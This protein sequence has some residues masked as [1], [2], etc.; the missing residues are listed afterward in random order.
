M[1]TKH[2]TRLAAT[3]LVDYRPPAYRV[4][5]TEL[6]LDLDAAETK[7]YARHQV[8]KNAAGPNSPHL[9]LDAE[10]LQ[11]GEIH[12][13]GKILTA[14]QYAYAHNKLTI[15][16]SP[17][18]FELEINNTIAPNKNTALSGLYASG[19]MLC[20]QCEA[21]GFRRITAGVD[22]PD[23]LSVYRV[24]LRADKTTMPLLL[25][26]GNLVERGELPAGKHFTTWHDPFPKPTYLF[27]AVAG[28]LACR[29][30]RFV[31]QSG[32]EV[33]LRLF[34]APRDIDKCAHALSALKRAMDWD[35]KN[36]GREYDLDA[37]HIVAVEN[38]NMGAMENKSLNIF[39]TKYILADPRVATDA[40]FENVEAVVAHEYFHNWSGNR[41]TCRDWFQLSL[42]EGFTVFREQQFCADRGLVTCDRIADAAFIRDA[43]FSE[44]SGPMAHAVR[45]DSY[46][47]INNFYTATVYNKGAEVIRMLHTILGADNFRRG[48][49]L[50]FSRHDGRAATTDDFV[51]AMAD[52]GAADLTAFQRW[53]SQAGTPVVDAHTEYNAA[54]KTFRVTLT[55]HCPPTPGQPTKLP[56]VIPVRAALFDHNGRRLPAALHPDTAAACKMDYETN[57]PVLVLSRPRQNFCFTEVPRPPIASLLRGFSAPVKLRQRLTA[58]ELATL[59]AHDDD[60]FN[61]R[62]AGQKL[63][64]KFL[65]PRIVQLSADEITPAEDLDDAAPP[66][67][68]LDAVTAAF[69]AML[70]ADADPGLQSKLFAL[71]SPDYLSEFIQ[72][73]DPRAIFHARREL[74]RHIAARLKPQL[75]QKFHQCAAA[76]TGEINPR[77]IG[78]RALRDACLVCLST[79][80]APEIDALAVSLLAAAKCMTDAASAL[81]VIA[82]S[83]LKNRAAL[84][85]E[86]YQR[87]RDEPLAVNKWLGIQSR[88]PAA[89]TLSRVT[90]LTRHP[91]FD[92][93]NPN[94]VY[95]L[96]LGFSHANPFCFHH[97]DGAGYRFTR[98]WVIRLD[99]VNPQ[100]SARLVSAFNRWKDFVPKLRAQMK[101]VLEDLARRPKLSADVAEIVAKSLQSDTN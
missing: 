68:I 98:D 24:T 72:P 43:Q 69:A 60:P 101:T 83:K 82:R 78:L 73:I 84:L 30:N 51:A 46:V 77:Q 65:L 64:L 58:R 28:E 87:N 19:E 61:R 89:D 95:A 63:M 49:D 55:Q 88:A 16:N 67:D 5:E 8:R 20:T 6:E 40:D 96:L 33:A 13:D 29:E 12:L 32:R 93:N 53:Y 50:Y 15:F 39:N 99:A 81:R 90:E 56:L 35:E 66:D 48:A 97:T 44:D 59:F 54:R 36:Y 34:A 7:V 76:N 3:R 31:T 11:L 21:E 2:T 80:E 9:I 1:K 85:D 17:A 47:E 62:E 57:D 25:C 100:V 10:D 22:R 14:A 4:V 79:L 38:F 23:N 41:V 75:L 92:A 27:A 86:F 37:Y 94:K 52:A 42:K 45:P 71:P 70:S 26:N 91:A 18:E 74:N